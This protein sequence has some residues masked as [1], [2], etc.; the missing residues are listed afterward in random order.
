MILAQFPSTELS[1]HAFSA[2]TLQWVTP[3]SPAAH[4][5][6]LLAPGSHIS[7]YTSRHVITELNTDNNGRFSLIFGFTIAKTQYHAIPS[8][9]AEISQNE[10]MILLRRDFRLS[11]IFSYI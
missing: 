11:F 2:D 9:G 3:L 4:S 8:A 1:P 7:L 10:M 6:P 5:H